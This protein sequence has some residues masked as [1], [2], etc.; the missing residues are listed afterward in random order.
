MRRSAGRWLALLLVVAMAS[1]AP[2]VSEDRGTEPVVGRPAGA[3]SP[4]LAVEDLLS[5]LAA[6]RFAR[7]S[8]LTVGG[9]MVLVALAEGVAVPDALTLLDGGA[10]EVGVNFWSAFADSLET[11]LGYGPSEIRVSETERLTEGDRSFARVDVFV[12]LDGAIRHL[13]VAED[14][15]WRIDVLATFASALAGK[16]GAAAETVRAHPDGEPLRRLLQRNVASLEI[17]LADPDVDPQLAQAV[18]AAVERIT[19]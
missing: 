13:V 8:D 11:F 17:V 19:R 14:D 2:A 15:G 6:G 3:A 18:T 10:Q 7:A 12:P 1:C 16:L 5:A 9:Q 4:E